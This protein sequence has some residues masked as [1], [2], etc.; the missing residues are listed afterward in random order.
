[1][2]ITNVNPNINFE[3]SDSLNQSIFPFRICD[4]SLPQYQTGS[5]YFF[6]SQKYT[7][8]VHIGSMLCLITTIR[9][10]NV[11]GYTPVT[12][13]VMN[14]RTF[15]LIAYICGF[16]KDRQMIEYTKDQWIDKKNH[17]VLQWA[18]NA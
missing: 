9:K 1:M 11:G 8:Y 17:N 15:V 10:D 14:L 7:S 5:V 13:N 16:K 18:R 12:D 3:S 2:N 4:I 6:M